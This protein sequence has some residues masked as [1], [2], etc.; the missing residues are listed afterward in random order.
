[1][2]QFQKAIRISTRGRGLYEITHH[3]ENIIAESGI[4]TG[5]CV[6]F[7]CHT[8]ASLMIQ[9]NADPTV[10]TDLVNWFEKVA[11]DGDAAYYHTYEGP[12]DMPSHIRSAITNSNETIPVCRGKMVLGTWQGIYIAEH[13]THGH[14]RQV[15]VHIIGA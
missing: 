14:T 3:V 4:Q 8:S 12:D 15:V 1:M 10:Q 9:E 11:P 7:I 2:N 13:R 6:V 5:I